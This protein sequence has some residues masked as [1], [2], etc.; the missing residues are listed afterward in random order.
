MAEAI[1]LDNVLHLDGNG[2]RFDARC[3]NVQNF[4]S[5]QVSRISVFW[6]GFRLLPE[7]IELILCWFVALKDAVDDVDV[8]KVEGVRV[9]F[10]VDGLGD[11]L[12]VL[13]RAQTAL[14]DGA[15][16]LSSTLDSIRDAVIVAAAQG[17]IERLNAAG[18]EL[19][20]VEA[21]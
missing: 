21:G 12:V 15:Q 16:S 8:E 10:L 6:D 5:F 18:E 9:D 1:V 3:P 20:K 13:E 14:D 2:P 19:A 7:T 4:S 17:R 11:A